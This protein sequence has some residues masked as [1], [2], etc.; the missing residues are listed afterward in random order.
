[1]KLVDQKKMVQV[2]ARITLEDRR[3]LKLLA[4]REDTSINDLVVEAI[5]ALVRSRR[6][7]A[8]GSK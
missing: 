7:P 2:S 1:M 4:A 5:R 3:A 8:A 6:K